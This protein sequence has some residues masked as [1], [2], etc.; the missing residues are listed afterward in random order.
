MSDDNEKP[1]TYQ[2][3]KIEVKVDVHQTLDGN[4]NNVDT[5][6]DIAGPS[7]P[8]TTQQTN[9]PGCLSFTFF[10]KKRYLIY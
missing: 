10:V 6:T 4:S 7:Y 2:M 5:N 9:K 8:K 3:T 1:R